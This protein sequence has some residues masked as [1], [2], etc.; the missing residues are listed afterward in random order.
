MQEQGTNEY[1]AR[2]SAAAEMLG[3]LGADSLEIRFSEPDEGMD[4]PVIWMAIV[5]LKGYDGAPPQVAA[6]LHPVHALEKLLE[7]LIDGG[8]CNHCGRMTTFEGDPRTV[9]AFGRL[10]C[11]YQYD[12]ELRTYRR[13]CE[14]EQ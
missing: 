7:Q 6:G 1:D 12:P 5:S 4:T 10:V 3:R 14:G 11:A 2:T 13:S 9:T 8:Q